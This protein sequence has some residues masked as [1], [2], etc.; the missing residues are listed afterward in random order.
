MARLYDDGSSQYLERDQ[1][2]VIAPP[3]AWSCWFNADDAILGHSMMWVGDKDSGN[4]F[5]SLECSGNVADDPV[6]FLAF[7]G[8]SG[9]AT[10]TT[11]YSVDTWHHALALEIASNSRSVRIDWG[12]EGTNATNLSPAGADRVAIGRRADLTPLRYMSGRMAEVGIWDLSQW[13]GASAAAKAA[14]FER[15]AGPALAARHAPSFFQLGLVAYW[16]LVRDEDQDSVRNFHLTAF[17]SPTIAAHPPII[18]PAPIWIA[19]PSAAPVVVTPAAVTSVGAV[20]DPT[21]VL[22]SITITPAILTTVGTTVD[23]TLILGSVTVVPA[24]IDAVATTVD[25]TVELGSLTIT[26]DSVTSVGAT[27]DPDAILGSVT[28][29]PTAVAGVGTVVAPTVILGSIAIAPDLVTAIGATVAPTVELGSI[30]FTP[31]E[32]AAV[33]AVV[34]PTVVLGSITIEPAVVDA[35]GETVDPA[36][37]FGSIA[38]APATVDAT[39]T[40]V[41]PT[42]L[43]DVTL[44]PAPVTAVVTVVDPTVEF[45]SIIIAPDTVEAIGAIVVPDVIL[46]S[47]TVT[48][49]N[50]WVVTMTVDPTVIAPRLV[51]TLPERTASLSLAARDTTLELPE[52]SATLRM[53]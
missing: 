46:G 4:N 12:S 22:G 19:A 42:V 36:V 33:G 24:A 37:I 35:V 15:V 48:P 6:Q 20:V 29:T 52:R 47:V 31:T 40:T 5:W 25:P 13:P 53:R 34:A 1:A 44:T 39:V 50:V 3:F 21:T 38:I 26:P 8:S 18:Y 23:P 30:S 27:V 16:R 14:E 43:A 11:G 45:G 10:T 51:V 17:N 7:A 9:I 28:V 41:D 49:G 2:P 32:V